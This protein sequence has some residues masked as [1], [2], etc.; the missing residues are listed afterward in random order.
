VIAVLGLDDRDALGAVGDQR[1]VPP[2][3]EQ[4]GLGAEQPGVADDQPALAIRGLGDLRVPANGVVDVLPGSLVDRLDRGADLLDVPYADRV[5]PARLSRR[6]SNTLVFQNPESAAQQLLA[7]GTGSLDASGQLLAE[8]Q[9]P[10]LRV[11]RSPAHPDVQHLSGVRLGR[12]DRVISQHLGV[13][14]AAPCF[15]RPQTSPTKL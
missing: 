15:K 6:Y 4:F 10:L 13:T 3:A 1:E 8:A 2:V 7:A 11:R 12:E 14:M 5:L 9:H